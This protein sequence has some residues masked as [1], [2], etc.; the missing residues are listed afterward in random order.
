M[1]N[2]LAVFLVALLKKLITLGVITST[3]AS[4]IYSHAAAS[5]CSK[6]PQLK[7]NEL[8]AAAAGVIFARNTARVHT[9]Y[10]GW[11]RS[12]S[13]RL[14]DQKVFHNLLDDIAVVYG[15]GDAA[16]ATARNSS[17]ALVVRHNTPWVDKK[18]WCHFCRSADYGD[19][20]RGDN[21][22]HCN[23]PHRLYI[24]TI[25][26]DDKLRYTWGL[27]LWFL[28]RGNPFVTNHT[29]IS[30]AGLPCA[31]PHDVAELKIML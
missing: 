17:R 21:V 10:D 3:P 19:C 22:R 28:D 24:H 12:I 29:A 7:H 2:F 18:R 5:V 6:L 16:A 13:P 31:S 27:G 14:H 26:V 1:P 25:C 23:V 4:T 8:H 9:M 20:W 15:S 11:I 30:A